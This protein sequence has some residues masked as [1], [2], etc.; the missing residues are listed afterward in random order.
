MGLPK[1]FEH[2]V[3]NSLDVTHGVIGSNVYPAGFQFCIGPIPLF[4]VLIHPFWDASVD[5]VPL[6]RGNM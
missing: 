5:S 1:T 2:N 3:T 4:Y 6:Y